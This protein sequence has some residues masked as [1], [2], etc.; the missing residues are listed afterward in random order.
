MLLINHS[1][2]IQLNF[3]G[4]KFI[5]QQKNKTLFQIQANKVRS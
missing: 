1:K 2:K 4:Q 5:Q 3:V